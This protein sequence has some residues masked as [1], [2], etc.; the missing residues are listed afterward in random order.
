MAKQFRHAC[1][2]LK[3]NEHIAGFLTAIEQNAALLREIQGALPPPL[4][5]HCLHANLD[6]GELTLITDSPVWSSRLR[7]FAPELERNLAIRRRAITSCRIRVEPRAFAPAMSNEAARKHKL[8]A[9]T[10]QHLIE[11]AAGINDQEVAAALRRLAKAGAA[12]C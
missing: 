9:R 12:G 3:R 6:S 4:N 1:R 8:S 10:R 11:V 2:F 5:E 7:F